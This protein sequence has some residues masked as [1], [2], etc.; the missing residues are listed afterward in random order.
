ME[1]LIYKLC[2][3]KNVLQFNNY[4]SSQ[5]SSSSDSM[6]ANCVLQYYAPLDLSL[7]FY[8]PHRKLSK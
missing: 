2:A 3:A 4:F 1:F 5:F 6:L 7:Q 8:F